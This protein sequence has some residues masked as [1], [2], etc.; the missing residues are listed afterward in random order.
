[1]T[2]VPSP[3]GSVY[4]TVSPPRFST[5]P[6]LAPGRRFDVL[7]ARSSRTP[8][9]AVSVIWLSD[10]AG[11]GSS[12][13]DAAPATIPACT[14]SAP[15]AASA[16]ILVRSFLGLDMPASMSWARYRVK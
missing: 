7:P 10:A 13:A 15:V 1:V 3:N 16:N 5:S 11:P 6:P 9:Q 8:S 14:T 12:A 4:S 2:G